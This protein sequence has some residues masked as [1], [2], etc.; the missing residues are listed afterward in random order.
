MA[1]YPPPPSYGSSPPGGQS[2]QV[3]TALSYGFNKYFANLG[4]VLAVIA[5]AFG[6]QLLVNLVELSVS[7]VFGRVLFTI[8]GLVVGAIANLGI[9]QT[10]L[11]LTQGE[12]PTV[13]R[14]F[15]YDRWGEW[16][17]FSIVFGLMVG[18]G[19][20]L[21]VIPGL[22][23]L[24][25][26]GMAPYFFIDRRMSLSQALS[27]SREAASNRGYAIPV[28]LS[29]IVGVLGSDRVRHRRAGH[30]SRRLHRGRVPLPQRVRPTRRT[31]ERIPPT[32]AARNALALRI[33]ASDC[34]RRSGRA[35]GRR[36]TTA[37]GSRRASGTASPDSDSTTCAGPRRPSS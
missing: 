17:G 25:L 24:A 8:V 28:L 22:F 13:G 20:V 30:R 26:F 7:S 16:I 37:C 19:L 34:G 18:I 23:V 21:C 35:G 11:M 32:T 9:Y 29:I 6:A 2:P 15:R 1:D 10:A 3:G 27:A 33:E 5:V 12:T 36:G 31:I 4:P 14:A